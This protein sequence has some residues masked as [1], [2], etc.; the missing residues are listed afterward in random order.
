MIAV[1]MLR[2]LVAT[3][4]VAVAAYVA[5]EAGRGFGWPRRWVWA[6]AFLLAAAL[7]QLGGL[8]PGPSLEEVLFN[9]LAPAVIAET[10]AVDGGALAIAPAVRQDSQRMLFEGTLLIVW[11]LASLA[12]AF[13]FGRALWRVRVIRQRGDAA[14]RV[15]GVDVIRSACFG[16][17]TVGVVRPAIMLP[18]WVDELPEAERALI[19]SHEREHAA[20]RDPLMLAAATL[21]LVAAPWCLPLWWM[22]RRLRD[23]VETDCDARVIARGADR[24]TY[25]HALLRAAGRPR[26]P[27]VRFAA[28]LLGGL[29]VPRLERR[30]LMMTQQ[31]PKQPVLRAAPL[32]AVAAIVGVV[33]CDAASDAVG[34]HEASFAASSAERERPL[35]RNAQWVE[36]P[37]AVV[38]VEARDRD[39][40]RDSGASCTRAAGERHPR[41]WFVGLDGCGVGQI[42]RAHV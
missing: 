17:A 16:P 27:M 10:P 9:R 29:E 39:R 25:G 11:A 15:D 7:P 4:L 28:P 22:H 37:A 35:V 19:V 2:L 21:V 34:V 8:V 5:E 18:R 32:I 23:A 24:L 20:A 14:V 26:G 13:G 1:W 33:A 40:S 41:R 30:I 31:R 6:G 36:M 38:R 12:L 3:A 42:G